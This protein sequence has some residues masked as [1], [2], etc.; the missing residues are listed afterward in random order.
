MTRH[1][2]VGALIAIAAAGILACGDAPDSKPAEPT[3]VS[4]AATA[5][6]SAATVDPFVG[7]WSPDT[8]D[9]TPEFDGPDNTAVTI[10]P[11]GACHL[12][13]FKVERQPDSASA[14]II[15]A[16]TCANARIRG[17]G[18]GQL[19]NAVLFWKAQGMIALPSGRTCQFKFVDGNRAERVA[20]GVVRVH[21][22][23]VV[24]DVPVS[25][26]QIVKKKP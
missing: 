23:G 13:E 15:F 11:D 8:T 22:N 19:S 18:L 16:A 6:L 10:V 14:S 3:S 25:G 1:L 5:T 21:Y 17:Q 7:A 24:C 26:T 12:I 9:A 20:E 4:T 2:F